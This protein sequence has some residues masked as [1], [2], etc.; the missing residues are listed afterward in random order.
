MFVLGITGGIGS[1]KTA[2]TNRLAE[3]GITI[4]DADKASRVIVEPGKPALKEIRDIFGGSVISENGELNR[5]ALRD[6]VFNNT[7]QRKQLE[8][9]THP[10]I[11]EELLKQIQ[12]STSAY[13]VLVSP[14]LFESSQAKMI[15]RSLVI[16]SDA[17]KQILRTSERDNTSAA[18][19]E[20]IIAVQMPAQERLS[21]ADDIIE[22][23]TMEEVERA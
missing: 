21:R 15:Q 9:I 6:I 4:V 14:L 7:Q 3:H 16:S 1:G 5:R 12:Q 17:E 22:F 2:V 8:K 10:R 23:F 20:K 11:G 18:D 13:T 19:V